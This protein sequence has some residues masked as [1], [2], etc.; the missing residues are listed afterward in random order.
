VTG[1]SICVG[2]WLVLNAIIFAALMLRRGRP[3][4]RD[5]L[6]RWAVDGRRGR[7]ANPTDSPPH[8]GPRLP[9]EVPP[10]V[11]AA[12]AA[13]L[14]N[15]LRLDVGQPDIIGPAVAATAIEWRSDLRKKLKSGLVIAR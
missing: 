12:L 6:F 10:D 8:R 13:G 14:A 1:L 7:I 5:R 3:V 15:E 4:L 11:G 2:G 9:V